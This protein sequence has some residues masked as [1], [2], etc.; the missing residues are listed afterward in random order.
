MKLLNIKPVTQWYDDTVHHYRMGAKV[1]E[2]DGQK[3]DPYFHLLGEVE[4]K[5]LERMRSTEFRKGTE[6]KLL[7]DPKK[8]PVFVNNTR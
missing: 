1:Y 3:V 8:K 5:H 2:D 7:V 6:V 4:R